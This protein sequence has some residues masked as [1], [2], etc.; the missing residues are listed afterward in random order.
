MRRESAGAKRESPGERSEAEEGVGV[1]FKAF[2]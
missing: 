2:N 1:G